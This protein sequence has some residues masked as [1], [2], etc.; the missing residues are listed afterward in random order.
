MQ[1]LT[2]GSE[3]RV[4]TQEWMETVKLRETECERTLGYKVRKT[5]KSEIL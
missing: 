2:A 3:G 4:T 1:G 5:P